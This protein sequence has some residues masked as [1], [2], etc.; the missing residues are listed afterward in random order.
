MIG[1]ILAVSLSLD[2]AWDLSYFRQP[3]TAPVRGLPVPAG[4]EVKEVAAT[5][6]GNCELDLVRAGLAPNP[7]IGT[8][9]YAFRKWEGCQWLYAKTFTF[10]STPTPS[11]YTYHIVFE[12][13]DTFADVFLNGEK[14]GECANMLIPHRFDVTEMPGRNIS[15]MTRLR[16]IGKT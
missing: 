8:N 16:L 10:H 3:E 4:I 9:S 13:V 11:L 2:G 6:P 14:V 15:C 5:V 7:E 1:L 12:G